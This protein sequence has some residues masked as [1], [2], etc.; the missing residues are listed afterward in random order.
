MPSTTSLEQRDF[1]IRELI[2]TES[3]YLE[4]LNALRFKF[5]A[6]MENK[7]SREELKM[8]FPK[9]REL[10]E[11][12]RKFLEKLRE[13]TS[14][15]GRIKLSQVFLDFREPFLIYGDYCTNM[16]AATDKLREV[17]KKSDVEQLVQVSHL[18]ID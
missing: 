15:N 5:M 14:P 2:D 18:F 12:H 16:T 8:I 7:L 10:A 17:S 4:V 6:P 13:A 11:I 9:I 3:N 1:V